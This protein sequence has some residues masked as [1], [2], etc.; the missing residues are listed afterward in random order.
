MQTATYLIDIPDCIKIGKLTLTEQQQAQATQ[1]KNQILSNGG[2]VEQQAI[3]TSQIHEHMTH[4]SYIESDYATI[5][6]LR[7]QGLTVTAI[8]SGTLLC[9]PERQHIL[10]QRRSATADI[11]PHKLACFG[12]HFTPDRSGHGFGALLDTLIDELQE[13]AGIDLLTLGIDLTQDLPPTFFILETDT[14]GIQFTPL[15]FALTPEQADLVKGSHEG[16]V[17]V[18]HLVNDLEFLLNKDNWSQMGYS[19]FT[20]WRELGFPVQKNWKE[21]Q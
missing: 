17:E 2:Y 15:A 3:C 10:L 13:E 14:G 11:Y 8:G 20:T 9:C 16:E 4:L 5:R 6:F 21:K 12:G 1:L 19:C 18:F 7:K